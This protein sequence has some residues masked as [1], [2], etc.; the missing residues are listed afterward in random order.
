MDDVEDSKCQECWWPEDRVMWD[1]GGRSG[2]KEHTGKEGHRCLRYDMRDHT[3]DL[4]LSTPSTR[5]ISSDTSL[6]D[7][8]DVI[9]VTSPNLLS[10]VMLVC[11]E[12]LWCLLQIIYTIIIAIV[13]SST[14]SI[15]PDTC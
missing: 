2:R 11:V 8:C 5:E 9:L 1:L 14:T 12:Y 10:D 4:L 13:S 15:T 6:P 7:K 3:P